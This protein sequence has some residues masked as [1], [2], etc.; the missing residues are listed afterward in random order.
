MGCRCCSR[1]RPGRSGDPETRKA[2]ADHKAGR[3][4][5]DAYEDLM[6]G[7]TDR[8]IALQEDI[9]LDVLMHGHGR[10]RATT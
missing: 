8:L 10:R 1:R 9:G 3:I 2:P 7:E 6:R 5:G 4:T